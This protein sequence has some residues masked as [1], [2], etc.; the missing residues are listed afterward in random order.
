MERGGWKVSADE[1]SLWD[2]AA[3]RTQGTCPDGLP[4]SVRWWVDG[5]EQRG[6]PADFAPRNG[7]VIVLGFD[8]DEGPPGAPPQMSS[9][10]LPS[11]GADL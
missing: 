6:D 3:H 5:V 8:S 10:F 11:L 2:G 9:L 7:Q 1:L 4:A